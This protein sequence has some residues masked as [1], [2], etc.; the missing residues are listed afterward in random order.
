[1][2]STREQIEEAITRLREVADNPVDPSADSQEIHAATDVIVAAL[3]AA[4]AKLGLCI[5]ARNE[6]EER[7]NARDEMI[8]E[9]EAD[10]AE[11]VEALKKTTYACYIAGTVGLDIDYGRALIAKHTEGE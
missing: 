7:I 6:L 4:E 11:L 5:A 8:D 9:L 1:M 10:I 3:R 2:N